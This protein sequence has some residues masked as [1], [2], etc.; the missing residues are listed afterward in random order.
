[1]PGWGAAPRYFS[2]L[3][4]NVKETEFLDLSKPIVHVGGNLDDATL[5]P[6]EYNPLSPV[7]V[8]VLQDT[9]QE[10]RETTGNTETSTGNVNSGVTAAA[11]I[12]AL[13]RASGKGSRDASRGSYRAFSRLITMCVELI[14]QFYDL[15][16]KF[17]ILG[18]DGAQQFIT[19][20]NEHL[21]TQNPGEDFSAR[22]PV[23]DIRIRAQQKNDYS[24]M[25]QNELAIQ[26]Y[27]LGMFQPKMADQALMCLEM[28]DFEGKDTLIRKISQG[29]QR[30]KKLAEYMDLARNLAGE[31]ALQQA[32]D[33]DLAALEAGV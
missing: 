21:K 27:Q 22:K 8:N 18:E 12:A 6:V 9:I 13:Q 24:A 7:Y 14:R 28:M 26:L 33:A 17:R 15:P 11:A 4:G 23:F 2:R 5:R 20:S 29:V 30:E 16:R 19:Y 31:P 25:A 32:I 3:D 1:M 10:L